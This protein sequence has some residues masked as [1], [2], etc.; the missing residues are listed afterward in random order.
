[1]NKEEAITIAKSRLTDYVSKVTTPSR[2]K[3]MYVCPLCKSGT[4]KNGSG[5]FSVDTRTDRFKCFSCNKSGDIFDLYSLIH[6]TDYPE[7][8]RGVCNELGIYFDEEPQNRHKEARN[9]DWNDTI[10]TGKEPQFEEN[11]SLSDYLKTELE[12]PEE[13]KNDKEHIDFGSFYAECN[14]ELQTNHSYLDKRGISL[15]TANHYNLG[16]TF[17]WVHPNST[18]NYKSERLI[19]PV[20]SDKYVARALGDN[21][22]KKDRY[23]KVGESSL[24]NIDKA[25]LQDSTETVYIVEGE[26]DC[27]SIYE[28]TGKEAIALGSTSNYRKLI[29]LFKE[30][31]P[32]CFL[33]LAL[34]DDESGIKTTKELRQEL[35]SLDIPYRNVSSEL[36]I[37]V[38]D[39]NEALQKDR[40]AFK[41]KLLSLSSDKT[42]KTLEQEYIESRLNHDY[43]K[44]FLEYTQTTERSHTPTGYKALDRLLEGGIT[45]GLYSISGGTSTG[46]TTL[47]LQIMDSI[48]KS[49]QDVIIF[50][51]EMPRHEL[52]ARSLSRL[53]YKYSEV[54]KIKNTG[55]NINKLLELKKNMNSFTDIEKNAFKYASEEY[56][57]IQK[58]LYIEEG[59]IFGDISIEKI[60]DTVKTHA[61][62]TGSKPIVVID[63]FQ[64]MVVKASMDNPKKLTDKQ[65]AD[66]LIHELKNLS[67]TLSIPVIVINSHNRSSYQKGVSESSVKESGMIEYTC[68]VML[69]LQYKGEDA[70][71]KGSNKFNLA[72]AKASYPRQLEL[73]IVKNRN[74]ESGKKVGFRYQS[75]YWNFE[76]TGEVK[77]DTKPLDWE[78]EL[79]EDEE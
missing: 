35:E 51:L 74:G 23:R 75:N 8:V 47:V 19:I 38:H 25:H 10:G 73:V 27:I 20:T 6:K 36:Y 63:Y 52:V 68:D 54:C 7:S 39:C 18:G 31:K 79:G 67:K 16:H 71:K 11:L 14:K 45:E 5:A 44:D 43:L 78:S 2:G 22:D 56:K 9:L 26:I 66:N 40:E 13:V 12:E 70:E 30:E 1:M 55:I 32:Q 59:E 46:K 60:L 41:E 72:K 29:K 57:K 28:A 69:G 64:I 48:A 49:G 77:L 21:V 50:S 24:F 58:H 61:R 65:I 62:I 76:E 17:N 4:G 42:P 3:N 34:D 15:E 53:T 33:L 37:E